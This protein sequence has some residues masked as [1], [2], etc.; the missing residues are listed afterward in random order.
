MSPKEIQTAVDI[1]SKYGEKAY[2]LARIDE[3][4]YTLLIPYADMDYI[5]VCVVI[6]E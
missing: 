4:Y 6:A 3:I 1:V 5:S 2:E